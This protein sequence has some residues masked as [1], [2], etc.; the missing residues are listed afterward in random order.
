[1][2]DKIPTAKPF[3]RRRW[4][5]IL[6]AVIA[7]LGLLLVAL[8]LGISYGL[9]KWLLQNGG[10]VV[11]IE[12]V[13]FNIFTGRASLKKLHVMADE[14]PRLVIPGLGLDVD[15]SPLFSRQVVVRSVTLE[16]VRLV[17]DVD[18]DG[19]VRVGGITLPAADPE[20][21]AEEGAPWAFALDSL[22][23]SDT[24]ITYRTPEL[25]LE[26][27]LDEFSLNDLS[28]WATEPAPLALKGA[29]NGAALQLDG[30]LPPLSE[31]NGFTG[32][33][34][35]AVLPLDTFAALAGEAISGLGGSLTLDTD[36]E[37][38]QSAGKPLAVTQSGLIRTDGLVLEQAGNQLDTQQLQWDGTTTVSVPEEGGGLHVEMRGGVTGKGLAYAQ[39]GTELAYELLQWDGTASVAVPGGGGDVRVEVSGAVN[40]NNLAL[41]I[42]KQE[43]DVQHGEFLWDGTV[44]VVSGE[45]TAVAANG[46]LHVGNLAADVADHK[47]QL[48]RIEDIDIGNIALQDT[49]DITL[50]NLVVTGA[51]FAKETEETTG[52]LAGSSGS[53]LVAGAITTDSIRI[54]DGNQIDIGIL[55]WRD[56]IQVV[57]RETDGQWRVV[58]IVNTLPFANQGEDTAAEPEAGADKPAGRVRVGELRVTGNSAVLLND[59]SV[60]PPASMRLD[61]TKA[62]L[63]NLDNGAPGKNSPIVLQ[64]R[65][66]KHSRID[67]QGTMQPFAERPTL[68]LKNRLEGIPL[69]LL[70]PYTASAMGYELR[71]GHLDAD[72][73]LKINKGQM[74]G[75]NK[76][77][78]RA[79]ELK[80]AGNK[81]QEEFDSKLSLPLDTALGMLRD[82]NNTITLDLPV[83]GD[84]DS[85]D[86]DISDVINTAVG[87]ALK[88][89]SMTY[90]KLAL[91]PYGTLITVAQLAG[92][93]ASKV[94]LQP[95]MFAPA[96]TESLG[97]SSDYLEKVAGILKA[98]PEVNIKVCGL[99]VEEDR[100]AL[101]APAA[102]PAPETG[103]EGQDKPAAATGSVSEEQL[104]ELASQRAETVKDF[105]VT[106]HGVTASRLVAC[107][108]Q[109]ESADEDNA[110]RVEL[111]I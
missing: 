44:N 84:I 23:I 99:A 45:T 19:I 9:H 3:F 90:L 53:V 69:T 39:A 97:E 71:S 105:L 8:P 96:S 32:H 35:L 94:R 24:T 74:D 22:D 6:A 70:S 54:A 48:A 68:D 33:I 55:E 79:L 47:I 21:V 61:V 49:G 12:D 81:S 78:I 18:A 75:Q 89:G 82:K 66:D 67:I 29:V 42:P 106:G 63:K 16:G 62:V 15:W 95:V 77:V 88:A 83:S 14:Q 98:R 40:G 7:L 100:V 46:H 1:M 60:Q 80:P 93:A 30:Q 26:T 91:Q 34:S 76:L 37:V 36:L 27:R 43:L 38:L 2:Q 102:T 58:R 64:G 87:K 4:F 92:E 52:K 59:L 110:P 103:K 17:I 11:Q 28:T 72:A 25:Q 104:L 5:T 85:P 57:R 86:F 10:D 41:L 73:T 101:A 65:I 13:D 108:P 51:V 111:L 56:V 20:V 50:E 107:Q 31:G 109:V